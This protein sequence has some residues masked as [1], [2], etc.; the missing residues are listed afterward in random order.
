VDATTKRGR[1]GNGI[2]HGGST[3]AANEA[4][5]AIHN[6]QQQQHHHHMEGTPIHNIV[7]FKNK[8]MLLVGSL[9]SFGRMIIAM[10]FSVKNRP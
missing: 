8:F 4:T 1:K 5:T 6:K 3:T 7:I 9:P 10:R 2:D